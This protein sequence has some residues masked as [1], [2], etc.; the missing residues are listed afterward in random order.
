VSSKVSPAGKTITAGKTPRLD[1]LTGIRAIAAMLVFWHHANSLYGGISSGMVG[2]SLFYILSGFVMAWV[3]REDDTDVLFYRRRFAKIYPAYAVAAV[4]AIAYAAV[5]IG[6]SWKDFFAF[7]LLQS[8]VPDQTVYYAALVVFWSLSCEAFFYVAFPLIRRFTRAVTTRRLWLMACVAAVVSMSVALAGV[9]FPETPQLMWAVVVFPLSRLPEF[10]IGVCLG[11]LMARGWRPRI[12]MTFAW[13][14]AA[15]GT[16]A[17]MFAPYSLSRYAVTLIPFAVLVVALAAAD[18]RGTRVF[19]SAKWMVRLGDW[20]Y[21]FYLIHLV[22]IM[23]TV[24][25]AKRLDLPLWA[26]IAVALVGSVLAAWI[27]HTMVDKPA[28]MKLRP[29]AYTLK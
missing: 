5:T 2:V 1:S 24:S 28:D 26:T 22:V 18:L 6:V 19:T 14:L 8:W 4:I 3:D 29:K 25:G 23:V 15:A 9:G 13:L 16:V 7:T 21:C 27:L 11:S 20:S 17:A 12:P 10:A